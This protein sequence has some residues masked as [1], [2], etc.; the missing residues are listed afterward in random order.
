[1]H[2]SCGPFSLEL[3]DPA[4]PREEFVTDDPISRRALT[5]WDENKTEGKGKK[6]LICR[7]R[8]G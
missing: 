7:Q 8:F 5:F 3:S 2:N 6:N 4:I 1:M